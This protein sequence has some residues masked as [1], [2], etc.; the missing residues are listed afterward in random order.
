MKSKKNLKKILNEKPADFD[1]GD[2]E[3][4]PVKGE[5]KKKETPTKKEKKVKKTD[6]PVEIEKI[7]KDSANKEIQT[8]TEKE[9][10]VEKII[11]EVK[12]IEEKS[13]ES[14]LIFE[15]KKEKKKEKKPKK[16][17]DTLKEDIVEIPRV[18]EIKPVSIEKTKNDKE[19][20]VE[21]APVVEKKNKKAK[22]ALTTEATGNVAFDELGGKF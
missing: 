13:E 19:V 6:K 18:V 2:W 22:S 12:K 4:V 15:D 20:T 8:E 9:V 16:S 5:K 17:K 3:K 10:S 21:S 7:E 11:E 14:P 1:E